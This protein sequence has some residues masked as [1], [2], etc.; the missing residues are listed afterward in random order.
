VIADPSVGPETS[1]AAAEQ[2]RLFLEH[3]LARFEKEWGGERGF[4]VQLAWQRVLNEGRWVAPAWPVEHGGRGLSPGEIVQCDEVIAGSG[5]PVIAGTLGTK[6]VGPTIIAWGSATQKAHL[7][8]ILSG[9]EIWCQGF[10]E[11]DF[12]SDLAGLR[13]RAVLDGDEFVVNGEKVWTTNGM[14][15]THCELLVRTDPDSPKHEGIS[16]LLTSLDRPGI[17]RRPIRQMTGSSD[18]AALTLTDVKIPVKNLLGP[19]N[20]GW[21]VTTTTLAHERSGVAIFATRLEQEIIEFVAGLA[22]LRPVLREEVVRRYIEGRIVG[23]MGK[24]TLAAV[25][26]G[27][28]PGPEQQ[29][30]KLAWSQLRQRFGET[31]MNVAGLPALAG[32]DDGTGSDFLGSRSAT[33]AA[34]TTEI[35]KNVLAERVLGL[36]REPRFAVPRPG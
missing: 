32:L 3:A 10:S 21:R 7:P 16:V 28:Q 25:V 22:P 27:A 12:G 23:A 19:M 8:R 30:I 4:E 17:E 24:K 6:N 14:R 11:P 20:E 35:V 33:I 18:F 36:P 2:L 31:R 29:V 15:A 13:T 26:A 1:G 9:E 34:G 5:A